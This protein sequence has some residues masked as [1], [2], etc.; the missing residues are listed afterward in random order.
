MGVCR[1]MGGGI[2]KKPLVHAAPTLRTFLTGN[3]EK[4]SPLPYHIGLPGTKM[5]APGADIWA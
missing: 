4:E 2:P 5:I 1:G 3:G